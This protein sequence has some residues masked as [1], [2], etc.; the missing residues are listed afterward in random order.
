M[1]TLLVDKT[2]GNFYDFPGTTT[3]PGPTVQTTQGP[4]QGKSNCINGAKVV[5]FLGVPY[6][7]P[8]VGE[9]R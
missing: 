5:S 8:P 4:I 1:T 2:E 3:S 9:L 7:K 6:A